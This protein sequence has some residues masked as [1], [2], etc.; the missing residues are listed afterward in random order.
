VIGAYISDI[1]S[2]ME[3]VKNMGFMGASF[4]IAFLI[5]PA[6]SGILSE[7]VSI[8]TIILI[9][10]AIIA[11]NVLSIWIFLEEPRRHVNTE[12]IHIVDFHFSRTVIT[13]FLLSFGATL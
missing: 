12:E 3:R 9:T 1:S 11:I 13:L 5:G 7:F 4:G 6:V 8:H 2:P 10:I